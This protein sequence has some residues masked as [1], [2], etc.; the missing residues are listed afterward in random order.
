MIFRAAP[1]RAGRR[2][3]RVPERLRR[4]DGRAVHSPGR[5]DAGLIVADLVDDDA[6][7]R[8]VAD[9]ARHQALLQ[10]RRGGSIGKGGDEVPDLAARETPVQ[11]DFLD[12]AIA[13]IAGEADERRRA[14][15]QTGAIH[16]DL[17]SDEA[18]D[19]GWRRL[20]PFGRGRRERVDAALHQR[21]GR[22]VQLR[23]PQRGGEPPGQLLG[24]LLHQTIALTIFFT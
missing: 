9:A 21:V 4:L 6:A 17:V 13:Q 10:G 11:R 23:P 20:E 24:L 5:F 19:D 16:D 8:D 22:R 12:P 15:R 18:D 7:E 2:P 14:A 3:S 1:G